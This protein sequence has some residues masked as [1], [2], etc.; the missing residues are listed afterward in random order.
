[1]RWYN[2][3]RMST[4]LILVIINLGLYYPINRDQ[5][6]TTYQ[7]YNITCTYTLYYSTL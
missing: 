3:T 1:M 5:L 4:K 7:L 2:I 6:I